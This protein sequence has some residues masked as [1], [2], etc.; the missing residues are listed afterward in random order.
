MLERAN[1]MTRVN[2]SRKFFFCQN[3]FSPVSFA[4]KNHTLYIY[5]PTRYTMWTQCISF[6]QHLSFSSTCF[7]P[8]ERFV[9]A[10]FADYDMWYY[11][12]YYS[13]RPAGTKL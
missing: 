12:A 2:K 8:H 1:F 3:C 10:V 4:Y 13:K 7:G 5:S 11:C 9:Q 6:N